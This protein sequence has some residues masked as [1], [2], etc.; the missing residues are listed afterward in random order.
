M[1]QANDSAHSLANVSH[2]LLTEIGIYIELDM[3]QFSNSS[4]D[5]VHLTSN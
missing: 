3:I 4:S 1:R 2:A 5:N